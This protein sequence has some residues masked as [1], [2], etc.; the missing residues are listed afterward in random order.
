V[1]ER[2]IKRGERRK[3]LQGEG[4]EEKGRRE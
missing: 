1:K 3:R 4:E 2:G